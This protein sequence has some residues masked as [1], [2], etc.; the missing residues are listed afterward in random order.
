MARRYTN[1]FLIMAYLAGQLAAVPHAHGAGGENQPSDHN[2]RP[3]F[4]VSWF[5]H[6]CHSHD[7]GH[8]HDHDGDGDG[9]HSAPHSADSNTS[10][11]GH[12]SDAVYL[13][14]E[15]GTPSLGKSVNL[16][17]S[18][19]LVSTLAIVAAPTATTALGFSTEAYFPEKCN[20]GCPLY[21]VLRALRI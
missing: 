15:I 20:S 2:A 5:E 12:D 18:P 3:H 19:E 13:P 17:D 1:T 10:H 16:L 4:H 14:N 9:S 21:L 11:D 8:T 6:G 7:H